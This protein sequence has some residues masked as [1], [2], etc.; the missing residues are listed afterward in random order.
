MQRKRNATK[1]NREEVHSLLNQFVSS[2]NVATT[3]AYDNDFEEH[4]SEDSSD[5]LVMPHLFRFEN[6]AIV[7][8]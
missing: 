5:R 1:E 3:P 6:H 7:N 8:Y 4:D 2:L